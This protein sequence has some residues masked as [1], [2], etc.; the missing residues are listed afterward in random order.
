MA[1]GDWAPRCVSMTSDDESEG[2]RLSRYS[3]VRCRRA[4]CMPR[5]ELNFF[6]RLADATRAALPQPHGPR[7]RHGSAVLRSGVIACKM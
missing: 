6:M 4:L 5:T 2:V 7:Q 3:I 1:P